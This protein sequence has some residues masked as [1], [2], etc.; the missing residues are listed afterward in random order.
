MK[1]KDLL[2]LRSY[3]TLK[4]HVPGRLRIRVD[5]RI[6][7]FP[8]LRELKTLAS[9]HRGK[10]L[11]KTSLNI[12]TQTLTLDYDASRV[13]SALLEGFLTDQDETK[14]LRDAVAFAE[15]LGISIDPEQN[16]TG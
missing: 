2:Q 11:G 9:E 12:F 3:F 16:L 13:D 15:T 8:H 5:P 10:R 14:V 4:D 7:A 1:I 6:L